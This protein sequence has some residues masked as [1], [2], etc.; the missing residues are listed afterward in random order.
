[1]PRRADTAAVEAGLRASAA[2]VL[3]RPDADSSRAECTQNGCSSRTSSLSSA[4]RGSSSWCPPMA[5][6]LRRRLARGWR[7]GNGHAAALG[8]TWSASAGADV[9]GDRSSRRNPA[10]KLWPGPFLLRGGES[11]HRRRRRSSSARL[12]AYGKIP[13]AFTANAGQTDERVR[14]SAQGAGFSVFLTRGEAMFALQRPGKQGKG[15]GAALALRFLGAQPAR[16]HP[17]RAPRCRARSTI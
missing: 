9:A 3:P 4:A 15:K 16:R 14:Y 6:R 10:P 8:A 1:M 13:L 17:R 5:M 11:L 7:E 12:A 2:G